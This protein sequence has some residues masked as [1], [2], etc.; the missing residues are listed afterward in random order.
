MNTIR[1]TIRD[2]ATGKTVVVAQPDQIKASK[3]TTTSDPTQTQ[4]LKSAIK[5]FSTLGM[6]GNALAGIA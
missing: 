3:H 5:A 1:W 2:R 4:A 6:R